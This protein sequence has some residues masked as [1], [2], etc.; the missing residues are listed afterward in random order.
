[1]IHGVKIG[2]RG[3][4]PCAAVAA[5]CLIVFASQVSSTEE[6]DL[7]NISL[8]RLIVD[9]A[10]HDGKR[11]RTKGFVVVE[12]EESAIYIS[13]ESADFVMTQ[14]GLW[15]DLSDAGVE[16]REFHRHYVVVEG[17]IDGTAGGTWGL[18]PG[19]IRLV[20]KIKTLNRRGGSES[21]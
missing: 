4:A 8:V 11:I 3:T 15:L 10:A 12:R 5:L 17:T 6:S 1:M 2:M 16:P 14:N 13:A 9:P 20:T 19:A 21:Q 7:E 18:F